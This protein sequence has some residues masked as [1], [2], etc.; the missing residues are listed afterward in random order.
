MT[1]DRGT[2]FI[3]EGWVAPSTSSRITAL[4]AATEEVLGTAPE[5]GTAEVD[6]A[7]AA[8]RRAVENSEWSAMA[9][10]PYADDAGAVRIANDS[11]YGLGG[12]VFSAD[13]QRAKDIARRVHTGTIGI[14][15]YPLAI[16]SPIGGVKASGLGRESGPEALNS[17]LNLKSMYAANPAQ[18]SSEHSS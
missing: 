7:V 8:A 16:G 5:A 15:G 13:T 1:V 11:V 9:V 10:I 12:T 17:Y 2:L 4:N 14:N 6:R 3:D 18:P